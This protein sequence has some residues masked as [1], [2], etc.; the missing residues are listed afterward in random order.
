MLPMAP[1][2]V[3][4]LHSHHIL[5]TSCHHSRGELQLLVLT[6]DRLQQVSKE[7]K[8]RMAGLKK[9]EPK[10]AIL[11]VRLYRPTL[12]DAHNNMHKELTRVPLTPRQVQFKSEWLKLNDKKLVRKP[13][14]A[15]TR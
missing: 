3:P 2:Y 10:D 12:I 9:S 14:V 5:I 1:V 4:R 13:Y 7:F 8:V 11:T 6:G 15:Q